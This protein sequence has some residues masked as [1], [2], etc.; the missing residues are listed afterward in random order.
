MNN[1]FPIEINETTFDKIIQHLQLYDMTKTTFSAFEPTKL[2]DIISS[3]FHSIDEQ[4]LF[5]LPKTVI[6]SILNND[7]LKTKND[8]SLFDFINKL[9]EDDDCDKFNRISLYEKIYIKNLKK[10]KMREF[11]D[12][13]KASKMTSILWENLKDFICPKMN[14]IP[15]NMVNSPRESDQKIIPPKVV[16]VPYESD[17]FKGIITKLGNGTA[18]NAFIKGVINITSN[19]NASDSYIPSK[20]LEYDNNNYYLSYDTGSYS[21]EGHTEWLCVDFKERKVKPSHYSIKSYGGNSYNL[22]NWVLEGSNNNESW[23]VLDTRNN[24]KSL[25]G[26]SNPS[27]TFEIQNSNQINEFYRYLRIRQT[28]PNSN[29]NNNDYRLIIKSLEYFGSITEI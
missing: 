29:T 24:D 13:I 25:D 1:L 27:I 15:Q 19:T 14:E 28:G 20:A 3:N 2:Y 8:D 6:F 10:E 26:S 9:F 16:N 4:K 12:C 18:K 17:K 7:H 22:Q 11:L 23:T 21:T 5:Q